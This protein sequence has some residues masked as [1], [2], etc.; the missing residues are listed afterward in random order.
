MK[1]LLCLH[2]LIKNYEFY[3]ELYKFNKIYRHFNH[4][5]LE[6]LNNCIK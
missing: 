2:I 4:F 1:L 3:K 6:K 5:K